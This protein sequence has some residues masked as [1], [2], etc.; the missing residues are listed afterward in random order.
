MCGSLCFAGTSIATIDA[1]L[2]SKFARAAKG[3]RYPRTSS[4]RVLK[5]WRRT[6]VAT[7]PASSEDVA[8]AAE[9][10][11]EQ[12]TP[13]DSKFSPFI[14]D[15]SINGRRDV[16]RINDSGGSATSTKRGVGDVVK[17]PSEEKLSEDLKGV[18]LS[19]VRSPHVLKIKVSGYKM[20]SINYNKACEFVDCFLD[21]YFDS[22]H[23]ELSRPLHE[24]MRND[25]FRSLVAAGTLQV[26]PKRTETQRPLQMQ[27]R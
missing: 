12:E 15:S 1:M 7:P 23:L 18:I 11:G 22:S 8:E 20:D 10:K 6:I 21:T 25:R 27:R 19:E 16:R 13:Q 14:P 9:T 24:A 5:H 26:I 3:V 17:V 2:A 4:T